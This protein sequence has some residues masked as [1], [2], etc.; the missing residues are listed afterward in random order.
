MRDELRKLDLIQ[1]EKF[2]S[3]EDRNFENVACNWRRHRRSHSPEQRQGLKGESY[4]RGTTPD[5]SYH[6]TGAH[7]VYIKMLSVETTLWHQNY[8]RLKNKL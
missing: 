7:Q 6:R 1:A 5:P 8:T 2:E 3:M 4:Y